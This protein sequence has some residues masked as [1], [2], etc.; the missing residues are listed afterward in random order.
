MEIEGGIDLPR[1]SG[2]MQ[3]HTPRILKILKCYL[4]ITS[5]IFALSKL[6]ALY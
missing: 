3:L 1:E 4:G 5:H 6:E 2:D